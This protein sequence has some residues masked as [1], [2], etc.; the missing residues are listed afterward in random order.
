MPRNL[1]HPVRDLAQREARWQQELAVI[2]GGHLRAIVEDPHRVPDPE[3]LAHPV[4]AG[5]EVLGPRDRRPDRERQLGTDHVLG[6]QSVPD[7]APTPAFADLD[8][9]RR[10]G[11][12][13]RG[14][15]EVEPNARHDKRQ[16]DQGDDQEDKT[17]AAPAPSSLV[18]LR[19]AIGARRRR[20]R[21]RSPL[22][23]AFGH[24]FGR[25]LGWAAAG[26]TSARVPG[27]PTLGRAPTRRGGFGRRGTRHSVRV[28]RT[29]SHARVLGARRRPRA[30]IKCAG[31]RTAR[32][33]GWRCT[34]VG[35]WP[36]RSGVA[37]ARWVTTFRR[38]AR[39][40]PPVAPLPI[41][42]R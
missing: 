12:A 16:Q 10:T 41:R 15:L 6:R 5:R 1:G 39:H 4:D 24:A 8:R 27:A 28:L 18:E 26:I 9:H 7:L 2:R 35:W 34:A 33:P 13:R 40:L 11:A 3:V 17:V 14:E 42:H 22:G 29:R 19:P 36:A 23:H 38:S 21:Q 37:R 30:W 31:G 20:L 25:G 32:W